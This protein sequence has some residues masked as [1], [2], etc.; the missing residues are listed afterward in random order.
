L[1]PSFARSNPTED[2]GFLRDIKIHSKISF[3]GMSECYGML[4]NLTSMIRDVLYAK[5]STHL[6]P[7]VSCFATKISLF[8]IVKELWWTIQELSE[9]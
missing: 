4:K 2:N 7:S 6:L 1:D 9:S 8:V 3:R 5:F